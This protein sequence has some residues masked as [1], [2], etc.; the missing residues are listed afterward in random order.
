MWLQILLTLAAAAGLGLIASDLVTARLASG[1]CA[2]HPVTNEQVNF[3]VQFERLAVFG[4]MGAV[5]T[6]F[7]LLMIWVHRAYRNLHALGARYLGDSPAMAVGS[8]FIPLVNLVMPALIVGAIWRGSELHPA[9]AATKSEG[10][11]P[12]VPALVVIW[13]VLWVA[14][15]VCRMVTNGMQSR[16]TSPAELLKTTHYVLGA[17]ALLVVTF[18]LTIVVVRSIQNMQD[19]KWA[20]L[21]GA[22]GTPTAGASLAASG[23]AG[24]GQLQGQ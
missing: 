21:G 3:A 18:V 11:R 16:A 10:R 24:G 14:S 4:T 15:G 22:C 20:D 12:G 1:L 17:H 13:W 19:R 6:A 5:L 7:I 8:F 2:G 9:V 23:A